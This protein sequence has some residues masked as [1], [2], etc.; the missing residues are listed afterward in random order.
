MADQS[1]PTNT[2]YV[3]HRTRPEPLL[4]RMRRETVAYAFIGPSL[5]LVIV[6][7]I[8]PLIHSV[9]MSFHDWNGITQ[10]Q[11]IGTENYRDLLSDRR[12]AGA[13]KNNTLY[14]VLFTTATIVLGFVL[15]FAI[16]QRMVGWRV[17]RFAFFVPFM[18][19]TAVIAVLWGQIYEPSYGVLNTALRS[20]GLGALEQL[21]LGNHRITILSIVVIAIWQIT[22]FTMLLYLAAMEGIDQELHDAAT[23]DGVNAWQRCRYV[24]LPAV[25]RVTYVLIML[26]IIAAL[27][28]FDLI[29]VLTKGGPF[30]ASE[31]MGTFLYRAAFEQQKFGYASAVAVVM[32]LIVMAVTLIYLR[33]SSM[34]RT[35]NEET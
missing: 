17:F 15:A 24:I 21:W 26:Q 12:F 3:A 2:A 14:L 30:Y 9:W 8:V 11:F 20:V 25:S 16:S 4:K 10:A 19:V 1:T 13:L 5:A 22:G 29:W 23:M 18:L 33:L 34:S 35:V 31:V 6:F 32:T 27:K 28:T 7:M